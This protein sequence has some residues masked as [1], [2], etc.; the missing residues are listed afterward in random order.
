MSF[1]GKTEE[2]KITTKGNTYK[3]FI[4][5]QTGGYWV[6]TVLYSKVGTI[7]AQNEVA[8]TREDAY[9]KAATFALNKI[10][11]NATIEPL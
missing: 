8:S 6:A 11:E 9:C 3:I 5:Q 1:I 10:D 2:R 7:T 4:T